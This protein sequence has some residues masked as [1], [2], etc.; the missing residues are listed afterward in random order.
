MVKAGNP[1]G[2]FYIWRVYES[3]KCLLT[4]S[5]EMEGTRISSPVRTLLQRLN[6]FLLNIK[7]LKDTSRNVHVRSLLLR[8]AF[9]SAMHHCIDLT[10]RIRLDPTR[11]LRSK[12]P[13]EAISDIIYWYHLNHLF[14][15][16]HIYNISLKI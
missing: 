13:G 14:P 6:Q 11:C 5:T 10:H 2:L 15:L 3:G 9:N 4:K 7:N 16:I 8:R 12:L 1:A